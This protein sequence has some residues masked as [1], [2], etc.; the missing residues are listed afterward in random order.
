MVSIK[1]PKSCWGQFPLLVFFSYLEIFAHSQAHTHARMHT[2]THT[3]MH[4]LTPNL[5]HICSTHAW[6]LTCTRQHTLALFLSL[7]LTLYLALTLSFST[8]S[9]PW[10]LLTY[11]WKAVCW[12]G[13]EFVSACASAC[14]L[15]CVCILEWVREGERERWRSGCVSRWRWVWWS[16][17]TEWEMMPRNFEVLAWDG[18]ASTPP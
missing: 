9:L 12:M 1:D 18:T 6:I 15:A 4:A 13:D 17:A 7:S 2:H 8:F 5:F 3:R 10:R 14:A 16:A 11:I